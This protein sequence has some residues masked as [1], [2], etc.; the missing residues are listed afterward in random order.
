MVSP[1]NASGEH[2]GERIGRVRAGC[3]AGRLLGL[4][5]MGTAGCAQFDAARARFMEPPHVVTRHFF[6]EAPQRVVVLPFA[7]RTGLRADERK[8]EGCRRVFYQHMC[9]RD[10]EDVE[11]RRCDDSVFQSAARTNRESTLRQMIDVVRVLDV[12]G[13]TTFVDLEALFSEH[14]LDGRPYAEI[15]RR[16]RDDTNADAYILGITRDF[17]RLYAVVFSTVGISTRVEM[18]SVQTGRL[19][20]RGEGRERS[21]EIPL[22]L[23]PLDVPRLLYDVWQHSRGRAMD[24]LAYRVYGDICHSIPYLP[25]TAGIRVQG[26]REGV[27]YY[28]KPGIWFVFAEGRMKPGDQFEFQMEEDGWF[29]CK[30]PDGR[31]V[32]IFRR[33]ARLTDAAGLAITPYADLD[34]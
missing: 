33:H 3:W 26:R 6:E 22:T 30:T 17:G 27:P 32:W 24:S 4:L 15:I 13:M 20:W 1:M 8:A 31:P 16:V 29:Q 21:Y 9:L 7:T 5:A 12:V 2:P 28:R 34:W 10:F 18:R 14:S 11:L 25:A 23:N 19:L